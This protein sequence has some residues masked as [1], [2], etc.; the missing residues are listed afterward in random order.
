[1]PHT[2]ET[3]E[4]T[5]LVQPKAVRALKERP[6]LVDMGVR[7]EMLEQ[8]EMQIAERRSA[9]TVAARLSH[10]IADSAKQSAEPV[11]RDRVSKRLKGANDTVLNEL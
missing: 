4:L 5:P 8:L 7:E 3:G 1:M 2:G 6:R 10:A 11:V 9:D